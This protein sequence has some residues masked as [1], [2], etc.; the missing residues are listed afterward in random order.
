MKIVITVGMKHG[1]LTVIRKI[2]QNKY[3]QTVYECRCDCGKIVQLRSTHFSPTRRFCSH[4][5]SL[6]RKQRAKDLTGK[7][8]GRWTVI[9]YGERGYHKRLRWNCICECGNKGLVLTTALT[10]SQ[11][12]SCGCLVVDLKKRHYTLQEKR[13]YQSAWA[14]AK[15]SKHPANS[16]NNKI[17]H[18]FGR[19]TPCWLTEADWRKM[20]EMYFLAKR[21][22]KET[23]IRHEVDHI[24]PLNGEFVSGLHVPGNLQ[25]LTKSENSAKR[26]RYAEL[27]GD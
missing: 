25:I 11:S 12:L 1:H 14:R 13:D 17:K 22:T 19:P 18:Y 27:S 9:S 16:V 8:F 2:G 3:S 20:D 7:K 4:G 26:N 24:I 23:G 6:L 5:C 10:S 15:R 21:L